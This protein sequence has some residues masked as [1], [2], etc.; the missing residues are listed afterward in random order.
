MEYMTIDELGSLGEVV[1]AIATIATLLYLALQIRA[2]RLAMIADGRRTIRS[3]NAHTVRLLAQDSDLTRVFLDG[4]SNSGSLNR[5]D[6]FRF[7]MVLNDFVAGIEAAWKENEMGVG[8]RGEL[9]ALIRY[10]RSLLNTPGGELW[11][12]ENSLVYDPAFVK[13]LRSQI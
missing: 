3:D 13:Y 1:A 2:G 8:N 9:D 10:N 5:E 12:E 7:R 11:L 6:A 4:L